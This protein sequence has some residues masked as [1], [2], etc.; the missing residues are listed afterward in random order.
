[1]SPMRRTIVAVLLAA[2]GLLSMPTARADSVS[3]AEFTGFYIM[4]SSLPPALATGATSWQFSTKGCTEGATHANKNKP[5]AAAGTC[6]ISA[7]GVI[8]GNCTTA[9][10][11]GQGVYTDSLGGQLVFSLSLIVVDPVWTWTGKIPKS[12]Q[13]GTLEATGTWQPTG[14][15]CNPIGTLGTFAYTIS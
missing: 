3:G 6:S 7:A 15:P 8:T 12:P 1:M 4:A 5:T 10:G 2:S 9:T 13:S 11:T 14:A